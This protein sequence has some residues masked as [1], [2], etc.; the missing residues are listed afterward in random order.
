MKLRKCEINTSFSDVESEKH[1]LI[2][3][4]SDCS[5]KYG[6]K[7]VEFLN[8]YHL[9]GLSTATVPQLREYVLTHLQRQQ[10]PERIF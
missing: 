8:L 9:Y 1:R 6:D 3:M 10:T 7:L 2:K 5:N 4:I